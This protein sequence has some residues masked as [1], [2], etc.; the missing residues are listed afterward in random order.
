VR[1]QSRQEA[2]QE[3][4]LQKIQEKAQASTIQQRY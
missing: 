1:F 4:E 2:K 3:Q